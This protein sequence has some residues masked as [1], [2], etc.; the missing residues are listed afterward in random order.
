LEE[1]NIW[2]WH[3]EW[4]PFPLYI[5]EE[6]VVAMRDEINVDSNMDE[7]QTLSHLIPPNSIQV[8]DTLCLRD[9]ELNHIWDDNI[10]LYLEI[11][12]PTNFIQNADSFG[13]IIDHSHVKYTSLS[14]LSKKKWLDFEI[15]I[16]YFSQENNEELLKI[17]FQ[18]NASI[19]KSY[20]SNWILE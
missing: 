10:G 13:A 15:I 18:G 12:E 7:S 16:Q 4:I 1:F 14:S 8:S 19:G 11:E 3:V 5:V 2:P 20:L 17:G 9:F 6:Y